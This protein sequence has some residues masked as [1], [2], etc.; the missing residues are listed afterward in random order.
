MKKLY[1]KSR[2]VVIEG[3]M[4]GLLAV[5]GVIALGAALLPLVVPVTVGVACVAAVKSEQ[6]KM[7]LMERALARD[8][9]ERNASVNH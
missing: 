2:G 5:S 9:A 1:E 4:I 7:D 3:V 8:N 6:R